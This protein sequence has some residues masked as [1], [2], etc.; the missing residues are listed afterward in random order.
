MWASTAGSSGC[1]AACEEQNDSRDNMRKLR[2]PPQAHCAPLPARMQPVAKPPINSRGG[3]VLRRCWRVLR[4]AGTREG[5]QTTG[6]TQDRLDELHSCW[7][8]FKHARGA[9]TR[10]NTAVA[11]Y[12]VGLYCGEVGEYWGLVGLYCGLHTQHQSD[13]T[14]QHMSASQ[15]GIAAQRATFTPPTAKQTYEVGEYCGLVGLYCGLQ[16]GMRR[17]CKH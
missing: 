7:R 2:T 5:T 13:G 12:E 1:T 3:R 9:H 4:P 10:C 11:A 15:P 17:K 14:R 16:Q 8:L 6:L